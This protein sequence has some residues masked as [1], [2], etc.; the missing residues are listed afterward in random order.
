MYHTSQKVREMEDAGRWTQAMRQTNQRQTD[1]QTDRQ[2]RWTQRQI[3]DTDQQAEWANRQTD[4][5]MDADQ[6][7]WTQRQLTAG[8]SDVILMLASASST[9]SAVPAP[10]QVGLPTLTHHLLQLHSSTTNTKPVCV[11]VCVCACMCVCVGVHVSEYVCVSVYV[12]VCVR[13]CV[14]SL[15]AALKSK[16]WEF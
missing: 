10:Q 11:C 13:M 4:R 2:T 1:K 7:G 14:W 15:V 3:K 8:N 12:C 9:H 5:Q 16:G 6:D